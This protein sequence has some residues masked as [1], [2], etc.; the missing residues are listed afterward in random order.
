MMLQ[1][2]KDLEAGIEAKIRE[3]PG[4]PNARKKYALEVARLGARLYSPES[5]VAWCGVT[6]PF[7]LLSAM[8][9]TS[10]FVEFIGAMLA[11]TGGI[12]TFLDHAE[13]SGYASDICGYHRSVL[14]S[15]K[16]GLMPVPDFLIATSCPC[17]GG[18]A[19]M[20]NL[21]EMFKK[22]LFILHIPQDDSEK[23][24]GFLA[25]QIEKMT[26]FV[27]A[28]TGRPLD[29]EALRTAI[30]NTNRAREVMK[31]IFELAAHVPSPTN[32]HDLSNFGIVMALL[33]GT[34]ASVEISKAYRDEFAGRIG[35]AK[36]GMPGEKH[37]L[38][39]IQ[40][41]IQFK[42]PLDTLLREQYKAN[43]VVDELN[44]ITW[45]PID[46][47][48]PF[49]GLARRAI[50]IPFNGTIRRR[51][52]HLQKL[53]RTYKIDGA[54]NPCHRGCRQ[55]AGARGL[56]SEGL[57]EI[58]I[59]VLNL[60]VDVVDPRDFAEGQ[61]ATRVEAFVEMLETRKSG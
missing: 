29:R 2:F 8:G 42:N 10:C 59:P 15:A 4:K 22:D 40:N 13:H 20:E 28:H 31:E 17:T 9:V 32:G 3:N 55:G 50:S 11:T 14:G 43:I 21:A 52:A 35:E 33:L 47:D 45:E 30:E 58:G 12:G 49:T 60:E 23:S 41:R 7:D 1:Y 27:A 36:P 61:L 48:D 44:S 57:K 5:R 26:E 38:M 19:V 54:I 51:T 18:L 25:D 6:A 53:A 24:V 34:E 39:W 16:Q 46:P 37:R 56:I